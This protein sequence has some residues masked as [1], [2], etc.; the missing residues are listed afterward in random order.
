MLPQLPKTVHETIQQPVH[1]RYA[2]MMKVPPETGL[3]VGSSQVMGFQN[4]TF[5]RPSPRSTG[6]LPSPAFPTK[7]SPICPF[8]GQ[9][10]LSIGRSIKNI[11]WN[12]DQY[13]NIGGTNQTI[14][15]MW[16]DFEPFKISAINWF[17]EIDF[18]LHQT[19]SDIFYILQPRIYYYVLLTMKFWLN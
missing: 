18:I 11:T 10:H 5:C 6:F 13:W 16:L 4:S 1:H 19:I 7:L 14:K 12:K 9:F 17:N 2:Q 3:R 8:L 15:L